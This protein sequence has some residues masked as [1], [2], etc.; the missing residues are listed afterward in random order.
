[1]RRHDP[2][3]DIEHHP[4]IQMLIDQQEKRTADVNRHRDRDK[5]QAERNEEIDKAVPYDIVEFWCDW[6]EEDFA[7]FAHKHV[8]VDWSNSGQR[9]AYHKSKHDC[10]NW[11]I[12]HITDK[13]SDPYWQ[14]SLQVAGDRGKYH[15]ELLQPFET[16]Y[17]LLYGRKNT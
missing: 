8:E 16:G 12:R 13:N 7:N 9:V 1:M 11:C 4:H 5:W 6:C 15:N 2:K 3:P 10:G 17:Q 14:E